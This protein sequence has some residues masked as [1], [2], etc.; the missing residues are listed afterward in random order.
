MENKENVTIEEEVV[1][2]TVKTE[3]PMVEVVTESE[4]N[5]ALILWI[6][7]GCGYFTGGVT[8]IAAV[9]YALFTKGDDSSTFSISH[10]DKVVKLFV[11]TLIVG[12]IGW[13]TTF[14]FI[15]FLIIFALAIYNGFVIIQGLL[16]ASD[17]KP[18]L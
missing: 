3:E 18:M 16:R 6:L 12:V 1:T 8:A 5:R 9:I 2:E 10:S 17:R 7:M 4:K 15:G 13:I 11:Q 14:I